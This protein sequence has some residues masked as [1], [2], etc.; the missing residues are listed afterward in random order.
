[1]CIRD[2]G[3]V[4]AGILRPPS[5]GPPLVLRS[6]RMPTIAPSASGTSRCG[7]RRGSR[8]AGPA[9]RSTTWSAPC[10]RAAAG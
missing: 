1:M 6:P 8:G 10:G 4:D 9:W 5:R 2:R 7:A 3:V